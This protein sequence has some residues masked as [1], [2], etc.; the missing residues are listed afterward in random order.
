MFCGKGVNQKHLC[1]GVSYTMVFICWA[2]LETVAMSAALLIQKRSDKYPH[3]ELG[4]GHCDLELG[5][6]DEE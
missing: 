1:T 5:G 2:M 4:R 6:K 3:L